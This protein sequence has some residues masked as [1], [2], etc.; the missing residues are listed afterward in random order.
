MKCFRCKSEDLTLA[1][2][3]PYHRELYRECGW[4]MRVCGQCWLYQNHVGLGEP[5][6]PEEAAEQTPKE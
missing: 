5:L 6:T 3:S 1:P 2:L 4:V